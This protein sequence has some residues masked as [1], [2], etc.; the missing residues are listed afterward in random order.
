MVFFFTMT[1]STQGAREGS[2]YLVAQRGNL[3]LEFHLGHREEAV[4]LLA[5]RRLGPRRRRIGPRGV[6]DCLQARLFHR[7]V[8]QLRLGS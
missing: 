6:E 1:T 4:L 8:L 3:V 7:R 5:C 2:P